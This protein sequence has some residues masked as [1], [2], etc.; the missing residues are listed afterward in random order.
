[1]LKKRRATRNVDE[2]I[3]TDEEHYYVDRGMKNEERRKV[4]MKNYWCDG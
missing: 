1:M 4:L 2:V 3:E